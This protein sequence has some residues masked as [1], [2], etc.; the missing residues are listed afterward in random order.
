MSQ[1]R[2]KFYSGDYP[3]RQRAANQDKAIVYIE[4]HANSAESPTSDYSMAVVA[5]NH[6]DKSMQM[7]REFA[8]EC[9][10]VF[11]VG[12]SKDVDI[13]GSTGVRIGGR[14]D[15][16]LSHTD[17]PAVLLEPVF[18]SNPKQAVIVE[19]DEWLDKL[20]GIIDTL[21]RQHFPQGGL[22]AFSIGHIG[23]TSAPK[24]CGAVWHGS[25]FKT[26]A[27]Y[28]TEYLHRAAALLTRETKQ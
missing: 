10:T 28:A 23:K 12:G 6:S 1:Y 8:S 3:A 16:N 17:M 26:E 25:R 7:A 27:E 14:G 18:A 11:D 19:S 21:V 24:D 22:V 2:V 5:S 4:G 13:Y 9:G 15:G 20:A